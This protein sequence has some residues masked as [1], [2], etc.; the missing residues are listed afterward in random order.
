M[1]EFLYLTF[2][3][4]PQVFW[5]SYKEEKKV[6]KRFYSNSSF[7]AVDLALKKRYRFKSPYSIS[8]TYHKEKGSS[9]FHVYGETPLTVF[10]EMF[11]KGSLQPSDYFIDLGCGRGRGVFFA[12]SFWR[13]ES[14]GVEL[15]P[16]FVETSKGLFSK[17]HL[18]SE[19]I[20]QTDLTFGTF[21]YLY[22]L[23]MEEKELESVI[24]RLETIKKNAKV[25][26]VSFP[27]T[28]Y[29]SSFKVLSSWE[30]TYPWGKTEV[31]LCSKK[32]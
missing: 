17:A 8:K 13:C 15:I 5:F 7:K 19:D 3:I 25:I 18:V 32:S 12:S 26:S 16:D 23:C 1:F 4:A 2:W 6:K 11:E 21:F 9:S 10:H 22:A 27:L 24:S 31:F 28:D 30:A 14:K 29:S 20:S